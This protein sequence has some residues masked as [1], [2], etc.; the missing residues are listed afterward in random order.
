M[1]LRKV[2]WA[3]RSTTTIWVTWR[4][5]NWG[6]HHVIRRLLIIGWCLVQVYVC[7]R[8]TWVLGSTAV[9]WAWWTV[10]WCISVSHVGVSRCISVR[11]HRCSWTNISL[12]IRLIVLVGCVCWTCAWSW[13]HHSTLMIRRE[14]SVLILSVD[15]CCSACC[16]LVKSRGLSV[17]SWS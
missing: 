3:G 14:C 10:S 5:L 17:N 12:N 7:W 2:V 11:C 1:N 16:C 9:C 6:V 15:R 13:T 4:M 8:I